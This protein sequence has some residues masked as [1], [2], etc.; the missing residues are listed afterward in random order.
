MNKEINY[1]EDVKIDPDAL[2]VEWLNQCSLM[3]KYGEH[4][5]D[6]RKE[7]D[8]TKEMLDVV[9]AKLDM[10]IRLEPEK[11][12]VLKVTESAIQSTILLQEE[13]REAN[14]E[15]SNAKYENDVALAVV[16]AIEQKKTALENLVRLLQSSYFAG[17]K[18]PRDLSAE[19]LKEKERK[20]VN[21]KVKITRKEKPKN[22]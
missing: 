2:D 8:D 4:Q 21:Q 7:M 13:Y 15:F 12:G 5:A 17:P 1:E 10:R 22:E 9:K 11:Y 16:R 6:T 18:A 20:T 3:K 19:V 14:E